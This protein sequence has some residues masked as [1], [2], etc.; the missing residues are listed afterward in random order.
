[1]KHLHQSRQEKTHTVVPFCNTRTV[2]VVEVE[3]VQSY[4][5]NV[6]WIFPFLKIILYYSVYFL[7]VG[8]SSLYTAVL[9]VYLCTTSSL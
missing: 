8:M 4:T 5:C 6:N 9:V 3:G 1:M 2:R 7:V